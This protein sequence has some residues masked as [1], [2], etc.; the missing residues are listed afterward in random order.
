TSPCSAP[1]L[2]L[3][4]GASC[5]PETAQASA[6]VQT[7]QPNGT[8]GRARCP[9]AHPSRHLRLPASAAPGGRPLQGLSGMPSPPPGAWGYVC[10]SSATP[11]P[12][13]PGSPG[14]RGPSQQ[15]RLPPVGQRAEPRTLWPTL[16]EVRSSSWAPVRPTAG[17]G[18]RHTS[19]DTWQEGLEAPPAA[20]ASAPAAAPA[21]GGRATVGRL[22]DASW[23]RRRGQTPPR[24]QAGIASSGFYQKDP[25]LGS[26]QHGLQALPPCLPACPVGLPHPGLSISLQHA[27]GA[28]RPPPSC[29]KVPGRPGPLP[30]PP[31][32]ADPCL[33]EGGAPRSCVPGLVNAALGQ[34]VLAS[35]TC[36]RPATRACDASD[37][38]RAHPAA[39]L[40]S[41]GG[42]AGPCAGAQAPLNVTLTVPLGTAF[43][44]VLVSPRFCSP[45]PAL[46]LAA[47]PRFCS[48]PPAVVALLKSQGRG[49][50]WAP[51]GFS[52][53]CG[54][55]YGR[56][57]VPAHGP[58]G[59]GPEALCFPEPQVQPDGGGLLAF[60]VQDG[61]PPGLDLDSSP[62][63]Q[64]WVTATDV[65]VVLTRPA[66]QGGPRDPVAASY[67]YSA[68]ELQVG[69]RCKCKGHASQCL[70]DARGQLV[71]DCRHGTE[72]PNCGRCRPFYCSRPWRRAT[73]REAHACLACSCRHARRCRFNERGRLPQLPA[74]HGRLP[75]P[76][77]PRGLYRAPSRAPSDRRAPPAPGP[78]PAAP[79][80]AACLCPQ[81]ATA[82]P[83]APPARPATRPRARGATG[84]T[85]N[86]C[87]PGFQQSRSPV[88]PCV[89]ECPAA[90][91]LQPAPRPG[92]CRPAWAESAASSPTVSTETPV[93]GS[94]EESSPRQAQGERAT[95]RCTGLALREGLRFQAEGGFE[96]GICARL[97]CRPPD[98]A[99]HCKPSPG[100]YRISLRKF[101]RR[102]YAVQV[103]VGARG[104]AR[105]PWTRFPVVVLAVFRSGE[106]RARRGSSALWVPA[107]DAACG[108]PP[109]LPGR[110]YLLLG[111]GRVTAGGGPGDRGRGLSATRGSLVLPWW[112]AWMRRLRRLQRREH[113]GREHRGRCGLA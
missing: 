33:D 86:R 53:R 90:R 70:L 59:P 4:V 14:H 10:L 18:H 67:F 40:T 95:R 77:L 75:L 12:S 52:S 69:R 54:L 43:E 35:S 30:S 19:R 73:A 25:Y 32:P 87:A 8:S 64:D 92:C 99:S 94:A 89:S 106:E 45:P 42:A 71:C 22:S 78:P 29:G 21:A 76:L 16:L 57:P 47:P 104:E 49:R 107:R 82:T 28:A 58:A 41:A 113:R 74:Q 3:R 93:P 7:P 36:G 55:D 112:D 88:A 13:W 96:M 83:S 20:S 48:P 17:S 50:S 5:T 63:L 1:S 34:E 85:C 98:C 62:V 111:G 97:P 66:S 37:P 91:P 65:R 23:G 68:A 80:T 56:P 103:A 72:G 15:V 108:C 102:D 11:G 46:L 26:P 9:D 61:S 6:S 24:G 109:L 100:S 79:L 31:T 101:C 51:L 44:L 27:P 60:S 2:T 105:G 84:L 110:R 81:P 38:R 39:L